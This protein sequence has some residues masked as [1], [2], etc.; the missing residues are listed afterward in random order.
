V[1]ARGGSS[2]CLTLPIYK[3]CTKQKDSP[4]LA[5][6][7]PSPRPPAHQIRSDDHFPFLSRERERETGFFFRSQGRGF[8]LLLALSSRLCT[9]TS[10][11]GGCQKKLLLI[12]GMYSNI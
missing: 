3:L 2:S 5:P 6:P 12:Y 9:R 1:C 4:P 10:W 8:F 11:V 7:P